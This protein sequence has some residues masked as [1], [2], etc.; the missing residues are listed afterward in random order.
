MKKL[1]DNYRGL[2]MWVWLGLG[3]ASLAGLYVFV[4]GYRAAAAKKSTDSTGGT[5]AA[6]QGNAPLI[7]PL[8]GPPGQ[9]VTGA[10]GGT[11]APGAPGPAGQPGIPRSI[12]TPVTP[13]AGIPAPAQTPT[14][15]RVYTVQAGDTLWDIAQRHY[16]SSGHVGELIAANLATLEQTARQHGQWTPAD[17]GH[18][19]YPGEQI[20]EPGIAANVPFDVSLDQ[21]RRFLVGIGAPT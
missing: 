9:S 10:T 14:P 6:T 2:P 5:L 7:I 18:W 19:I 3:G 20:V 8:P 21:L 15:N 1:T 17:P 4:R 16:G 11:G 12:P 13:P